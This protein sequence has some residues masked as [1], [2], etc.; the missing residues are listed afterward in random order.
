M[1]AGNATIGSLKVNLGLN[2]AEF[3]SGLK[4]AQGSLANFGKLATVGLA[5]AAAAAAVAAVAIGSAIKASIDAA[6][7]MLIASQKIG[8]GVE[9]LSALKYAADLSA[10][11]FDQLQTGLKKLS[12]NM[13][14][15]A[16][17]GVGK[18]ADAFRT[19]GI[20]VTDASGNLRSGDAVFADVADK[21]A[22]MENGAGKTA[23]A[24]ALFGKAGADLIPL[25]NEGKAGLAEMREE[26]E[27]LGLIIST[28]TAEAAESFN[29]NLDRLKMVGTGVTNQLAAELAP[30]LNDVTAGLVDAIK[31]TNLMRGVGQALD[32]TLKVLGTAFI[33]IS[34]QVA[35]FGNIIG[36]VSKA[37]VQVFQGDFAGA[38]ETAKAGVVADFKIMSDSGAGI[39]KIWSGAANENKA[40]AEKNAEGMAAPIVRAAEK[41]KAATKD[42]ETEAEKAA[43]AIRDYV[44]DEQ[45]AFAQRGLSPE[46]IKAQ[47]QRAKASEAFNRGLV[48]QGLILVDLSTRFSLAADEAVNL[49]EAQ[50]KLLKTPADLLPSALS[51]FDEWKYSLI[52]IED[53]FYG[54]QYAVEDLFDGIRG[55]NWVAAFSG[56]MRAIDQVKIAFDSAASSGSRMAAAAGAASAVGGAIGGKGG[57][58]LSG[59]ASGAATGFALGGPI[60][61]GIGAVIGGLG[62][63]LGASKAKKRA[64]KEAAARAEQQRLQKAAELAAASRALDIELLRAQGKA[65]E[66]LNAQREDELAAADPTLRDRMKLLYALQDQA[67]A[68]AK[69]AEAEAALADVREMQRDIS[70]EILRLTDAAAAAEADRMDILAAL[71]ES[72]RDLQRAFWAV[73]DAQEA[74]TA[75][76][77]A[78]DEAV[79]AAQDRVEGARDRLTEAYEAEAA[80][81]EDTKQRFSALADELSAL[82]AELSRTH[83]GG[84]SPDKQ[85]AATRA[86]FQSVAGRSDEASLAA[87][88]Q[89]S[90]DYIASLRA[91]A[92][93]QRALAAGIADV[94]RA[95]IAGEAAARGQVSIAESQLLALQASVNGL[96][97]LNTT[98]LTVKTALDELALAIIASA[99][100]QRAAL[101]ALARAT[102]AA[103]QAAASAK[104]ANDNVNVGGFDTAAATTALTTTATTAAVDAVT[105][106]TASDAL[107]GALVEGLGPFLLP[108]V[109]ST[110]LTAELAQLDRDEAEAA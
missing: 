43:K 69:A 51:K 71:P 24:V 68:A 4:K 93:N 96:I 12:V 1:A 108:M 63:L 80:V 89:A 23:L 103:A 9:A 44:A 70:R 82:N 87:L 85:L 97:T 73:S 8:V 19:L 74:L 102:E 101:E 81:I 17:K 83:L 72:L 50:T 36:T 6:D 2:S 45:K 110:G 35:R 22:A 109:K 95:V 57:A 84:L 14:D 27:A 15:A 29:D 10:V 37:I 5:A 55:N 107:V 21:F 58:A 59:A 99:A 54:M 3:Q 28:E 60:G 64:K 92:P 105:S 94:R 53:Q 91:T 76:E 86:Q 25:L 79:A 7:Q 34:A 106:T 100:E 104:V 66:A 33:A 47:E 39:A 38:L 13:A 40:G 61:A 65:Q 31:G 75:A 46:L 77:D 67:D 26:A 11:S 98:T 32:V 49:D 78:R 56:L 30:A 42:I 52:E 48:E 41:V 20:S 18:A 90:R 62:G 88:P 16:G